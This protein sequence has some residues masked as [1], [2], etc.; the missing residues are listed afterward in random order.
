M[1]AYPNWSKG[2]VSK[3][4]SAV[5]GGGSSSLPAAAKFDFFKNFCYN[6]IV[7]WEKT[8]LERVNQNTFYQNPSLGSILIG[9]KTVSKTAGSTALTRNVR[10]RIP[11]P[12][13]RKTFTAI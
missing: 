10:V 9:K 6:I 5:K 1:A 7:D 11:S 3:T 4:V 13:P 2:T 8:N 12:Q